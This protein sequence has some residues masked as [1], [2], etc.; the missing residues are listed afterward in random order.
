MAAWHACFQ[1]RVAQPPKQNM[2]LLGIAASALVTRGGLP[3]CFALFET[4]RPAHNATNKVCL[5]LPLLPIPPSVCPPAVAAGLPGP[6]GRG[7]GLPAARAPSHA[8]CRHSHPALT[9]CSVPPAVLAMADQL[10]E[11]QI[12]EFKEAFSLFDKVC[13]RRTNVLD[14][15]PHSN[16]LRCPPSLPPC[17]TVTAPS[18]PRSLARSCAPWARTPRRRS[19][20]T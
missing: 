7:A 10:T 11:E 8:P 18:P 3:P 1:L 17:R 9:L 13:G 20:R 2:S 12:A 4:N 19:C 14:C 16:A 5:P 15:W 6:C